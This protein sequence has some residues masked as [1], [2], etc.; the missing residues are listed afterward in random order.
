MNVVYSPRYLSLL[1]FAATTLCGTV[2]AA[3]TPAIPNFHKV[4]QHIYRG[5]QP[6]VEGWTHLAKLGVTTVLDLRREGEDGHSLAAEKH[7][8]EK[9]GM[10]YVSVP[11]QGFSTPRDEDIATI[12]DLFDSKEVVFVHCKEGKDRTGT[13]V[14]CY[15][16]ARDG[17]ENRQAL[18]EAEKHGIHWY[19]FHMK[20]YVKTFEPGQVAEF[21]GDTGAAA[22]SAGAP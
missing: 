8:V 5:G 1:L 20:R 10:R 12:L 6:P 3:D 7:A 14:A 4:N 15:R 11:T 21:R 18:K 2:S 16:I 22:T 19:E 13:A 9:A 17:W